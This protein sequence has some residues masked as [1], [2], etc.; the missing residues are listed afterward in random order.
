MTTPQSAVHE[1]EKVTIKFAGDS[2]DGMQLTGTLFTD[3]SALFGND[4]ATFPDYPAEIRAP[5]GTVAGVSGFQVQIGSIEI[6]TP[7][8]QADAL[9]AMNPAALKANLARIRKG[10]TIVV[11]KDSWEDRDLE[12]AEY[13]ED[14]LKT[15]ALEGFQVI[16]APITSLT[17]ESLK[18]TA[19]D[20]KI[21][22]RC[23]N[24]FALG[25]MLWLY[26]R[27]LHNTESYIKEKFGKKPDIADA[28]LKVLHA[29]Y[30]FA[31][32]IEQFSSNYK[33]APAKITPG[34]YRQISGNQATAFGMV[35]ASI[36]SGKEMLLG[37]YPITPAS[38]ILHELSQFKEFGVK[39]VQMEDEIAGI[40]VAIGASYAGNL[41]FTSTSGPGLDLKA[42]ALSLAIC[43]ELPLVVVDV[44]RGGPS[45]GLPTKTEQSD[46][47][48]A[49]YGRHGESPCPVVAASTPSNCFDYTVE[50]ARI[51]LE[52]MTPVVLLTDGYIANGSEPWIIPD[53]K[54]MKKIKARDAALPQE[55]PV[56]YLPY[57]RDDKTL[58]RTWA[59]PGMPGLEHRIGGLEKQDKTGHVSYD[60]QNHE[61]MT[62]LRA[63]KV[64]RIADD[65][66][67]QT[68]MGEKTGEL[69]VVGW[70]GTYGALLTAV[71]E[72]QAEGKKISLAH[73][74]YIRPLPKNTGDILK[75]FKK[76]VVCELNL[77][78]FHKYLCAQFPN[79]NIFKYNKVQ[80][81]PFMIGELKWHFESLLSH[82]ATHYG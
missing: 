80:G 35:A 48:L 24:M 56:A 11:D 30:A 31:N 17:R 47:T 29:G 43:T 32:T 13:K 67:L 60:P 64:N 79:E 27:P 40:C 51:A 78:Q 14:P 16:E 1:L 73:F 37:A 12:K 9:V 68:V 8:D 74:N 42:E 3:E 33:I 26:S 18:D 81:L 5:A 28:N 69:L 23:K 19:L 6:H 62:K 77:G 36:L 72:L 54:K 50:A 45:T 2:G 70:G 22:D 49:L 57:L 52:H 20:T 7:G 41:G 71:K 75:N 55:G 76:I 44:Q 65:I 82:D 53:V 59:I 61:F 63:E 34:T 10:A 66:P 25:M 4:L 21:K 46:L 39:T 38:D 58:A 15:G